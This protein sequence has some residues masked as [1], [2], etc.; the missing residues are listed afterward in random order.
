MISLI[1]NRG[2]HSL[3]P[4]KLTALLYEHAD[5]V[6]Q[7]RRRRDGLLFRLPK[8]DKEL[9]LRPV[10]WNQLTL[11]EFKG[12]I[13]GEEDTSGKDGGHIPLGA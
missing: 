8:A 13:E 3:R 1:T 11:D 5:Q 9:V 10:P 4:V 12:S 7:I 2:D 6:V